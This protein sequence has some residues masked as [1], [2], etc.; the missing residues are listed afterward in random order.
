LFRI[1]PRILL[2]SVFYARVRAKTQITQSIAHVSSAACS[3]DTRDDVI[4]DSRRRRRK[5]TKQ[6]ESVSRV[7]FFFFFS[8]S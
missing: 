5:K 2:S 3:L 6:N 8:V 1:F 4:V 7:L